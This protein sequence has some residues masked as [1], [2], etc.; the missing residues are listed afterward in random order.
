MTQINCGKDSVRILYFRVALG[1]LARGL[2]LLGTSSTTPSPARW[3]DLHSLGRQTDARM[4]PRIDPS[5]VGNVEPLIERLMVIS[6]LRRNE[7]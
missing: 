7:R 2:H 5:N 3:F 1:Q 4:Q 6:A